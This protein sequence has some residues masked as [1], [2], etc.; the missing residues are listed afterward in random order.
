MNFLL[1]R[2]RWLNGCEWS[3]VTV[4]DSV[5][6]F[7]P[8]EGAIAHHYIKKR[9]NCFPCTLIGKLFCLPFSDPPAFEARVILFFFIRPFL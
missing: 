3:K 9:G 5:T 7:D 4:V 6:R 1:P 2:V 8:R